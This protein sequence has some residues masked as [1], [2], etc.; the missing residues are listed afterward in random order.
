MPENNSSPSQSTPKLAGAPTGPSF[1]K[2]FALQQG[3]NSGGETKTMGSKFMKINF[4][5]VE[6]A[7]SIATSGGG[8]GGVTNNK[9]SNTP[10]F[11]LKNL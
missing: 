3:L 6:G 9:G 10:E 8:G 4:D 2:N 5:Q 1:L 11:R 7:A